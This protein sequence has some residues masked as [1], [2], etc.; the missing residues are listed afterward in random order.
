MH[1]AVVKS[2]RIVNP[3]GWADQGADFRPSLV[4]GS[5]RSLG[6]LSELRTVESGSL[7]RLDLLHHSSL[8]QIFRLVPLNPDLP[9]ANG[10]HSNITELGGDGL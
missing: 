10:A 1:H 4:A 2:W 8:A 3:A 6:R 9:L 7:Q 5:G